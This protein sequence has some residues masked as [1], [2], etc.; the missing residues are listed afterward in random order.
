VPSTVHDTFFL[1]GVEKIKILEILKP[2]ILF[3]D[4]VGNLKME[5]RVAPCVH[6]PF[7]VTNEAART[8]TITARGTGTSARRGS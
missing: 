2:H 4:Q 5:A 1:G 6:V 7:G 8:R 3:E